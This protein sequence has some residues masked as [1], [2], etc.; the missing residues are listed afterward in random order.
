MTARVLAS[1]AQRSKEVDG[2]VD[3]AIVGGARE[4]SAGSCRRR[5]SAGG[6]ARGQAVRVRRVRNYVCDP[7][8][9]LPPDVAKVCARVPAGEENR[10]RKRDERAG[11]LAIFAIETALAAPRP[12]APW[13]G[14]TT[15]PPA[16]C[17]SASR[18]RRATASV[19]PRSSPGMPRPDVRPEVSFRRGLGRAEWPGRRRDSLLATGESEGRTAV[20]IS[21]AAL[22][23]LLAAMRLGE[24]W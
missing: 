22:T 23:I 12:R 14:D 13:P 18:P 11:H 5:R 9:V 2:C 19:T 4:I 3:S 21:S 20:A 10:W 15:T 24:A 6:R 8:T 16:S 7:S 17:P 1:W